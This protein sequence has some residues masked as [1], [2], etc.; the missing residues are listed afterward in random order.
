MLDLSPKWPLKA[1]RPRPSSPWLHPI[2]VFHCCPRW[3][4]AI[5]PDKASQWF[6]F[7]HR[8]LAARSWLLGG[9][10]DIFLTMPANFFSALKVSPLAG[11][12][13]L[14]LVPSIRLEAFA[15]EAGS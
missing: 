7:S 15:A 1:S 5:E 2:S 8:H 14:E 6:E 3:F 12:C 13:S 11:T 4:C 9:R 10:G